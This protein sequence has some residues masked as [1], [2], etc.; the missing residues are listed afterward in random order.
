MFDVII[1]GRGPAGISAALY[2]SRANLRTLVISK[3]WGNLQKAEK[4]HNYY[5]TDIDA[6]GMDILQNGVSQAK[7]FG[8]EF[9]EDEAVGL[10]AINGIEVVGLSDVYKGKALI[11]A[12][13]AP[14]HKPAFEN[15]E[16]FEG[17]GISYCG[18][19]DGFFYKDKKIAVI[20]FNEFM[21]HELMELSNISRDITILTNGVELDVTK[22]HHSEIAKFTMITDK[23]NGFYGKDFLE[24][25]EF[26]SGGKENFEGIFVAYGSASSADI[27]MKAGIMI[28]N[29]SIVADMEMKTNLPDIFA[30]GDCT[31]G[32]K[33]IAVAVGEGAGAA[34]SAIQYIRSLSK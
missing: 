26:D 15:I 7:T 22:E 27:A 31:G 3:D 4:V 33:Q 20:G 21:V 18:S 24:G 23:I 6:S 17:N 11:L 29:G 2:T 32:F 19:C 14:K 13:G 16:K 34:K 1:I 10:N 30:A 28:E 9:V 8:V 12:M 25:V 5:G